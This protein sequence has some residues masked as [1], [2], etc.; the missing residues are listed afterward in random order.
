MT[1]KKILIISVLIS[2]ASH[3]AMLCVTGFIDFRGKSRKEDVL[4][5]TLKEP[6]A[7]K[8]KIKEEEKADK[9][10]HKVEEQVSRRA[11]REETV[12]LGSIDIKYSSYLKRIKKK[13]EDIWI[14]PQAAF[15]QEE[16]GTVVVRFSIGEGGDLTS[17]RIFESSGHNY[18]DQGA[19]DVVRSAAPYDPLPREFNISQLNVVARFQYKIVE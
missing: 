12:D 1:S 18:L 17:S 19:L 10:V 3:V 7:N 8:D 6:A 2:L 4:I 15:E 14:Y 5:V 16:E 13:I 9:P 11:K